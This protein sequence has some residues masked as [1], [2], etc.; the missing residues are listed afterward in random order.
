MI[1]SRKTNPIPKFSFKKF[2][3]GKISSIS[4]CEK[5]DII[6]PRIAI[7]IPI[8]SAIP[9]RGK[10]SFNNC[11]IHSRFLNFT[12]EAN[13]K[14]SSGSSV[15]HILDFHNIESSDSFKYKIPLAGSPIIN[16]NSLFLFVCEPKQTT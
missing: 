12:S 9:N 13:T 5:R 10:S 7:A 11:F 16:T 2:F 15:K 1:K 8:R 6:I 14:C 4:L 3:L